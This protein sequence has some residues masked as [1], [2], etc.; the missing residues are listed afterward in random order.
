[1]FERATSQLNFI[2]SKVLDSESKKEC[3][4]EEKKRMIEIIK[5]QGI[6][7]EKSKQE[8]PVDFGSVLNVLLNS[9][10]YIS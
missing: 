7:D 8:R 10:P 4:E 2:I 3:T 1:M 5:G 6:I 9:D